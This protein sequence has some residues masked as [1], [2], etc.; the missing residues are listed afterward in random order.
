MIYL[1]RVIIYVFLIFN[2]E[3]NIKE[4][5]AIFFICFFSLRV[6]RL[7]RKIFYA[8]FAMFQTLLVARSLARR[9][10]LYRKAISEKLFPKKYFQ[11]DGLYRYAIL[12]TLPQLIY[13]ESRN[14]LPVLSFSSCARLR[15]PHHV[16][17]HAT[18]WPICSTKIARFLPLNCSS[19]K[20]V[21]KVVEHLRAT[22]DN[23]FQTV[24]AFIF[25]FFSVSFI[26]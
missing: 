21:L 20:T 22:V 8:S 18:S 4:N 12:S 23:R 19:M 16:S 14:I 25:L 26:I 24:Y 6:I 10:F 1:I 17:R 5:N 3:F 7:S 2:S 15:L 9:L 13:I 11:R